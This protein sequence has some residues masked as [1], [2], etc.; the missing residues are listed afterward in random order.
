MTLTQAA[1]RVGVQ[2]ATLRRWV[3]HGLIPQYDGE[4][5][6]AA[7]GTARVVARMRERG[8]SLAQIER[9]TE[10]DYY[11]REVNLASRVAARSAG[12]EVL[13]TRPVVECAGPQ[14]EFERIAEVKLKGLSEST[15]V[16]IARQRKEPAG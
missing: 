11:G 16:F 2:P 12:G 13:V 10:G 7:I 6:P 8:H 5:T 15:E 3:G 4:W 9:A 1:R 14:L